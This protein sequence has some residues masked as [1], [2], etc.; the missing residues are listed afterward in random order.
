VKTFNQSRRV[1]EIACGFPR[2]LRIWIILPFDKIEK[3]SSGY[4]C[5]EDIFNFVFDFAINDDQLAMVS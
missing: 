4:L 1:L 5:I 3:A 2:I